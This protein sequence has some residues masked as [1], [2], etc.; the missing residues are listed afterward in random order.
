MIMVMAPHR[1]QQGQQG[2]KRPETGSEADAPSEVTAGTDAQ[3]ST[4]QDP[5][6][7][8]TA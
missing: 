4:T 3:G 5:A 2:R 6:A 7:Q 1:K 8:A